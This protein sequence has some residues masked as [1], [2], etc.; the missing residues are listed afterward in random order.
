MMKQLFRWGAILLTLFALMAISGCSDS[1]NSRSSSSDGGI[2]VTGTAVMNLSGGTGGTGSGGAGGDFYADAYDDLLIKKSGTIDTSF[3]VPVYPYTFGA[4]VLTIAAAETVTVAN[5]TDLVAGGYYLLSNNL[6]LGDGDGQ[7]ANDEV[8]DLDD[9]M[10]TG[11]NVQAGGTLIL[12]GDNTVSVELAILIDGTVKTDTESANLNINSYSYL[13]IGTAGLVTTT[14]TAD[15]AAAG[16]IDLWSDGVAINR[17]T[18]EANGAAGG[19][20]A[21]LVDFAAYAFVFNTGTMSSNGGSNADGDGG[22]GN[23]IHIE[24]Y[25]ASLF[26]SGD[27]AASG[28]AGSGAGGYVR[29]GIDIYGGSDNFGDTVVSGTLT[30]NGGDGAAGNGRY[31]GDI[32]INS[33]SSG[34]ILVNADINANGGDGI[35]EAAN[36]GYGGEL[37]FDQ[38]DGEDEGYGEYMPMGIFKVAGTISLAGG[39]GTAA[40]GDGGYIDFDTDYSYE[41]MPAIQP[42][43]ILGF[44][45][46]NLNGGDSTDLSGGDGGDV[47]C[48]TEDGWTEDGYTALPVGSIINEADISSR[49]GAGTVAEAVVSGGDGGEVEFEAEGEFSIGDT[50]VNNSGAIDISGGDANYAGAAGRVYFYGHDEVVNTATIT[51]I[52]G[53]GIAQG[54]DGIDYVEFYASL[55]VNNSGDIIGSGGAGVIGGDSDYLAMYSGYQTVNSG[56][57]SAIGGDGVAVGEEATFGG[58][59]GDIDL[60]SEQT[61]TS[62]TGTIDA[63]GGIGDTAGVDGTYYL[64]WVVIPVE[65]M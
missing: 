41:T 64:D 15:G 2:D 24:S 4:E 13:E 17:G 48:Y 1:N 50:I 31:A 27:L 28:G 38:N 56:N 57:L 23:G 54:G 29:S 65:P 55:N 59:G 45:T 20:N 34:A 43:E 47:D 42:I 52:G 19:G 51:G 33:D 11:I 21:G 37:Y 14:A 53:E 35:G 39:D 9:I 25:Y 5:A 61:K 40:G 10:V 58:D 63:S 26:T 60:F 49:G 12:P 62:N 7:L 46:L 44:V 16:S 32:N 18:I 22:D 8:D 6:Y 36:G 30:S 3:T